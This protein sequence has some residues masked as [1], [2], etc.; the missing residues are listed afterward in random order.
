MAAVP[1]TGDIAVT[2]PPIAGH[3]N[4]PRHQSPHD[5]RGNVRTV[6]HFL[7]SRAQAQIRGVISGAVCKRADAAPERPVMQQM[8][9]ALSLGFA[10][11]VLA[12]HAAFSQT[13]RCAP[14]DTV[15]GSLADTY[16]ETRRGIDLAGQGA[17]MEVYAADATGT[18]TILMTLPNGMSCMI[19]SGQGYE[20]VTDDLPARGDPA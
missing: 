1:V 10:G 11:V 9:F 15:T 8:F 5:Q 6:N 19:A 14:R 7:A 2:L 13:A 12:G 20:A 16:G 18:W 17:V 3:R 4:C